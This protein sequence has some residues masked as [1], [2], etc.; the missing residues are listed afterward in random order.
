MR[1]ASE[2]PRNFASFGEIG[3]TRIRPL[4]FALEAEE[5]AKEAEEAFATAINPRHL[6]NSLDVAIVT[7]SLLLCCLVAARKEKSSP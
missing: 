6:P 2:A 1:E 5:E 3:I 7:I 4:P